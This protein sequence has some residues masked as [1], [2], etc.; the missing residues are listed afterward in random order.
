MVRNGLT[1]AGYIALLVRF[2]PWMAL[3]VLVATIPA[4]LAEARFSGA[5]FRL[6]NWRSPDSRRLTYLEYSFR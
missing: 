4:F 5:A 1:L 6:R 2:S 3:A